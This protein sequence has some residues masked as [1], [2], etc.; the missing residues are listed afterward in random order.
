MAKYWITP[1][2]SNNPRANR[3]KAII[4][5]WI[6]PLPIVS[7]PSAHNQPSMPNQ[8]IAANNQELPAYDEIA[9]PGYEQVDKSS[10]YESEGNYTLQ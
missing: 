2:T 4:L 5:E 9:P 7:V 8:Q 3:I 10:V 1:Y 6:G